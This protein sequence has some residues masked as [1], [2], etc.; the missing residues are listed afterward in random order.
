MYAGTGSQFEPYDEMSTCCSDKFVHFSY[1]AVVKK[2]KEMKLREQLLRWLLIVRKVQYNPGIGFTELQNEITKEMAFRGGSSY[3]C[4]ESTLKRDIKE[5]REEFDID[6]KYN[7]SSGGYELGR[8]KKNWLDVDCIV[9]PLEKITAFGHYSELP[10]WIIPE[11]YHNTGNRH[12]AYMIRAIEERRKISFGYMKYS[13]SSVSERKLS[14]YAIKQWRGRWYVVGKEEDGSEKTFGMDRIESLEI[15]RETYAYDPTFDVV[16]KFRDSY[17][18]YSSHEYPLEDIVLSFDREDG[19]YLKS[20]PIHSSQTVLKETEDEVVFS[21][22]LRITPDF[23][24]E[25]QSRSWSVK[26]IR[27]EFLKERLCGIYREAL[28]R[29]R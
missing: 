9:E 17:G 6:L 14:P 7:R 10:E 21:F 29:N 2:Q 3:A 12:L 26:V 15:L 1:I 22:R 23:I 5:L 18:I 24:M 16:G 11:T 25:L 20:R 4:S 13:D 19:L 28:E 8:L 27:P